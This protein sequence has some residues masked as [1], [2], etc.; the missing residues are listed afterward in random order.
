MLLILAAFI[1]GGQ[2]ARWVQDRLATDK[3]P[4]ASDGTTRQLPVVDPVRQ[5]SPEAHL[6]GGNNGSASSSGDT[7]P[8]ADGGNTQNLKPITGEVTGERKEAANLTYGQKIE[9]IQT[10]IREALKN[11]EERVTLPVLGTDDDSKI[12][13]DIIEKIILEDPEI[14]F[15]EGCR[16]RT[17][18]Q[19][20]LRYSKSREKILSA[21]QATVQRAD[22]IIGSIIEPG[23]TDFEKELAIH[24]YIVNN[25]RYDIENLRKGS[26]PPE[27]YTAYGALVNGSAVCEG[28][29]KAMKLLLDRVNI[30]S[31]VVAG[32][33][34]GNN[35]AWNM[36]CLD[37]Q[38]YHVDATWDDPVMTGGSQ[39]L[40]HVYFNLT[41]D[42]IQKDHSW[43]RAAYP[44]C[45]DTTYNYYH[46]YGLTVTSSDAFTN[47]VGEA[48]AEGRE[49]LSLRILN[50]DNGNYDISR[51][52]QNT[53]TVL[54][55]RGLTYSIN[56]TY[57]VVDIWLR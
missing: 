49:H 35:H 23:M 13:F 20:T 7:G 55:L 44:Q 57:G 14:M 21:V 47:L 1:C 42:E 54:G 15:Y 38:Y 30:R 36:V 4:V 48:V 51:L 12:I 39:V 53:A 43:N 40:T 33:S 25:C 45:S 9:R 16:Y 11:A 26:T 37:G 5:E 27:A 3:D 24:D 10:L 22:E 19:L 28:Y 8:V 2:I 31:L 32:H 56:D 29:A 46:Y 50:Y 6:P 17:D 41:D 52:I 34:K 18:G